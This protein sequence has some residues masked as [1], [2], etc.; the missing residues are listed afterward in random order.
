ML[1]IGKMEWDMDMEFFF[2]LME[3]NIKANGKIIWNMDKESL[4]MKMETN[5]LDYL[6]KIEWLINHFKDQQLLLLGYRILF[7]WKKLN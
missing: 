4:P 1:D 2:I 3:V 6:L 7:K 5:I